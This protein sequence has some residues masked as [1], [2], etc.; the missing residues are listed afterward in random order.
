MGNYDA[1]IRVSTKVETSQM[2]K[3]QMQIDK[4]TDKVEALTKE[5]D[6]LKNKKIPTQGYAE[7]ENK[8]K[9]AKSSLASLIAEEEKLVDAGLAMGAPWENVLKKEADAQL[10]IEAIQAEM[11]KLVDTG[12]AFTIG[13]DS[14][15]ISNKEKEL[16]RAR[17]ELRMLLTKQDEMGAKTAKVSDGMRKIGNVSRNAF[18]A[19][20]R[21]A[22]G[23][24]STISRGARQSG[25]MLSTFAGRLKGLAASAFFF[26]LI[27]KG[28]NSMVSSMRTGFTNLMGYSSSFA[29]SIQ[30]VKNSLSTLGN[31]IAAAFA[32]IIQA[33][34]PWLNQLISMIATAMSYVSQFISALTGRSTYI[35]AKRVQDSFNSSLGDTSSK[36]DDAS[37]AADDMAD[38][39]DDTA[40]SARKAR[41]ALAAFDDLDVLEKQDKESDKA[42]DKIKDL[43]DAIKDLGGSGSGIGDLFEEV[44][45]EDNILDA[46]EKFKDI[47]EKLF[48]PLKKAWEREGEFVMKAW[49]YA[50]KEIWQLI[51]DIGRDF[52]TMWNQEE[53]VKMLADLLHIFGD[54]GLIIGNIASALDDAWNKNQTGLHILENIRDIFAVIIHNIR[55]AADY[56]VEWSRTLDFS[57]ILESIERLTDALVPFADF[58]SGTLADF[59]TQFILPLTSW[60]LSD[61]GLP[62]L[63][64]ILADFMYAVDWEMLREALKNLYSALEPYAE[65]VAEGLIDF[66]EKIKDIGV[67]ILN[68][69]PGPIQ[70]LADA[71]ASGDPQVIRE[72][73]TSLLEFVTAIVMLKAAFTGFEVVKTGLELFL[74]GGPITVA[75]T[76][77]GEAAKG[78]SLFSG[79]LTELIGTLTL[80]AGS[81]AVLEILKDRIFALGEATG[82]SGVQIDLLRE[83][84]T[85]LEGDANALKDVVSMVENGLQGYGFAA[86]NATGQGVALEQA[87]NAIADGMIYSD[88]QLAKLQERFGLTDDDIEMLRQSMLD[89]NEPLRQL[90]DDFGLFDASV[91]TLHEISGGMSLIEQG[92]YDAG[93]AA[94][95]FKDSFPVMTDEAKNFFQTIADSGM[96]FDEYKSSLE[97]ASTATEQFCDDVKEAGENIAA[98]ITEGFDKADVETPVSG[99]FARTVEAL[100]AVFDMHSPAKN[101]EPFGE[102]IFLGVVEGFRGAFSA[103]DEAVQEWWNN[104]VV[105]L[106]SADKWSELGELVRVSL[107]ETW[108][109]IFESTVEKWT[110]LQEWF[111]EYWILFTEQLMLTWEEII[112]YFAETW[113]QIQLQFELFIEFLNT[114]FAVAWETNWQTARNIFQQFYD[115]LVAT[116]KLIKTLFEEFFRK[117]VRSYIE[118]DWKKVWDDAKKIFEQFKANVESIL[119][120]LKG[121]LQSFFDW[122]REEIENVLASLEKIGSKVSS[123]MGGGGGGSSGGGTSARSVRTAAPAM[124]SAY[125]QNFSSYMKDLPH[126]ASGAVIRG[127]NPYVA[128]LGDQRPG[129]TNVETPL[130]TIRQAVREEVSGMNFGAGSISADMTL[131]GETVGRL[132][133]P[134][135]IDEMIRQGY[136]VDILGVT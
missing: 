63:V 81:H 11:Q 27:S 105:P 1:E 50:L 61:D 96:T 113:E 57:P 129:Q 35:R 74:S 60:T 71:L 24:F 83:R 37:K 5:Y 38:S 82:I 43:D 7:L 55:E 122:V 4:T 70:A 128:V 56:T 101:M 62:R 75:G 98:G 131:D 41:G 36:A 88:A 33:V 48:A 121:T 32:P 91:E 65:A 40:D 116:I 111:T 94:T 126:L 72:L 42:A 136:D 104:H 19:M 54:I 6:E 117:Q 112:L 73:V 127:G 124:A 25:G 17:A 49:K 47:L 68:A 132:L 103:F 90:A 120:D 134:Y 77:S 67:D 119:S 31:Q 97:N 23:A 59:Y 135:I 85:G 66:I 108:T 102:N 99:F 79:A 95:N 118:V 46:V 123:I 58:I 45:I 110:E 16:S 21:N 3:L 28:F 26:N 84:Y 80:I 69:I 30:S 39:L 78:V 44:P 10:Q 64:N 13:S 14:E 2:Q 51:K 53:T 52:L 115:F 106:F 29:G 87:M 86:N 109:L 20:G 114:V 8:L 93:D 100:R 92:I 18:R 133:V 9:S 89:A 107:T 12:K 22:G 76:T 15:E 130:S 125:V 34:I